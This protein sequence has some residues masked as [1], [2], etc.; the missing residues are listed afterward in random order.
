MRS[1]YAVLR[2]FLDLPTSFAKKFSKKITD[3]CGRKGSILLASPVKAL[4]SL[5]KLFDADIKMGALQH[6]TRP[7]DEFSPWM[8]AFSSTDFKDAPIEMPGI[9]NQRL[10]P[11]NRVTIAGFK[12]SVLVLSSMRRPKKLTIIGSDGIEYPFLVKAGEDL[13][14]DQRVESLFETMNGIVKSN[15]ACAEL[16]TTCE[17]Y[18]VFPL[19]KSLGIIEWVKDTKPLRLCIMD[20]PN[21]HKQ[22]SAAQKKYM[23][24]LSKHGTGVV[25]TYWNIFKEKEERV[26]D[27]MRLMC[28]ITKERTIHNFFSNLAVSTESYLHLRLKFIKS[29]AALNICS[30]V[31]GIGDRH[32]ENYLID[33]STGKLVGIDFGH[34]FGSA[35][36]VLPVPELVP[37]RHTNQL[38]L[39]LRP[40]G[41]SVMLQDSMVA[42]LTALRMKKEQLATVLAI[43]VS[44]PLTEWKRFAKKLHSGDMDQ[45]QEMH[46]SGNEADSVPPWYPKRKMQVILDKLQGINPAFI[47]VQELEWAH[48]DKPLLKYAQQVARGSESHIRRNTPRICATVKDQ[49][50]CLI[51]QASDPSI[52]GRAWIGWAGW[53]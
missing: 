32:S 41:P 35:T 34:A 22:N 27:N 30:Y 49:V 1:H 38:D 36:E 23:Q 20:T 2:E 47:T 43:F 19:T 46:Y 24:F 42:I 40:L 3:A 6:G 5:Q 10:P 17:T 9:A 37:F 14:L 33:L 7:L 12:Q 4:K 25:D 48:A 26:V 18:S 45:D 15:P 29:L 16:G 13:R 39:F 8:A 11:N 51:D 28:E 53:C 31:L 50:R 44:E 21:F 52:L